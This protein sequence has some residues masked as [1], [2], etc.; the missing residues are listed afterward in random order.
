[1][2]RVAMAAVA[3]AAGCARSEGASEPFWGK[4]PCDH[5]GM[6]LSDRRFGAQS[7]TTAGERLFFDDVGCM[8]LF[9][10]EHGAPRRSWVHDANTGAW[11]DVRA[12]R[13]RPAL[14]SPMD[15]GFD[16]TADEG[17]AWSE[18]RVRVLAKSRSHS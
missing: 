8:V 2:L 17:I 16:A 6:V 4:Q 1:M 9:A 10:E 13:Y 18:M 11:L 7:I 15:F 12:A 3:I 14:G 5:C